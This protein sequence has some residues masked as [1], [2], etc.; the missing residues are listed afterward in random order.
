[1]SWAGFRNFAEIEKYRPAGPPPTHTIFIPSSA[2][3]ID[4]EQIDLTGLERR[5]LRFSWG[6]LRLRSTATWQCHGP[7]DARALARRAAGFAPCGTIG[8]RR[9][10]ATQGHRRCA[11]VQA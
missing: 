4:G 2:S 5:Q 6:I 7:A 8:D 10:S 11:V 1:M 3:L 9:R